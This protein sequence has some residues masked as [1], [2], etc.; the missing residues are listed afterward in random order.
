[1]FFLGT[2]YSKKMKATFIDRQGREQ[3]LEMGCYG[4]G[5]SRTIQAVIEQS[6][7]R[8]GI[9]WPLRI[10]PFSTI[11]SVLDPKDGQLQELALEIEKGIEAAGFD[12]LVDDREE[13][14]GVKFKDADLLGFPFRI[15]LGKRSLEKGQVEL[16]HRKNKTIEV[17]SPDQVLPR[18]VNI[19]KLELA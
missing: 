15:N 5:V 10:A 6:H 11:L 12:V 19:L 17:L 16:I 4:I 3:L 2:K 1:V 7:D 13:R 8:D 9:V 18:L 14:P